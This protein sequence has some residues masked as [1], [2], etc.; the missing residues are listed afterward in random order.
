MLTYQHGAF[1]F[2]G[3]RALG[4][5]PNGGELCWLAPVMC[6]SIIIGLGLDYDVFLISRIYEFRLAGYVDHAA[7]LKGV[8]KTGYIITAAGL[9]MTVAFGGLFASTELLLNQAAF[10]LVV[11][12]LFDTFVVRTLLVPALF[13]LSGARSWWPAPLPSGTRAYGYEMGA[14]VLRDVSG[15]PPAEAEAAGYIGAYEAP[16]AA[17]G[18]DDDQGDHGEDGASPGAGEKAQAE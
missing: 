6:F 1:D 17:L 10:L 9:I 5:A 13:A 11:S 8:Y 3:V 12:V 18:G 15:A 16:A 4:R 2:V 7:A 14:A